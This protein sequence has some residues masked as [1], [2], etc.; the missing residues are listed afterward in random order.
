MEKVNVKN[1]FLVHLSTVAVPKNGNRS[2]VNI[3]S[4]PT[5][6]PLSTITPTAIPPYTTAWLY[7]YSP[8][9]NTPPYTNNV[10]NAFWPSTSTGG[11]TVTDGT[12][13]IANPATATGAAVVLISYGKNGYGAYNLKGQNAPPA[14]KTDELK[15]AGPLSVTQPTVV[16][17][18]TTDSTAGGGPFDDI[19]MILSAND[20]T[21]PLIANGTL[22]ANAQAALTQANNIVLGSIVMSKKSCS[23]SPPPPSPSP[24]CD[25]SNYYYPLNVNPLFPLSVTAWGMNYAGYPQPGYPQ[26]YVDGQS[27]TSGTAYI[28]TAGD[29]TTKSVSIIELR[30][31]L[32]QAAGFN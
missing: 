14:A 26:Q 11:I 17:R 3:R 13:Q 29:G 6:T 18:D 30:G 24:I 20:L 22:Q 8:T 25:A 32:G 9:S 31:I 7:V 4:A 5:H 16:K 21:G 15:N 2:W 1:Q 28:L 27:P 19:V 10:A 23:V 12:N